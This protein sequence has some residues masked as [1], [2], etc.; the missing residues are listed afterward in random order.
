VLFSFGVVILFAGVG[1]SSAYPVVGGGLTTIG[2][3]LLAGGRREP[4]AIGQARLLDTIVVCAIALVFTYLL[5]PKDS[6]PK[7]AAAALAVST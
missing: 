1:Y 2:S 3:V 5:W 4:S 6:E 7:E